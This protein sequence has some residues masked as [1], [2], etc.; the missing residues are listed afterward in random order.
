M[1]VVEYLQHR[2]KIA[3]KTGHFVSVE[4]FNVMTPPT[5]GFWSI[6]FY[7]TFRMSYLHLLEQL[8]ILII[9]FGTIWKNHIF[10]IAP[11]TIGAAVV[12]IFY[13]DN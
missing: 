7:K 4:H 5:E 10:I 2:L 3:C 13:G 6:F 8:K 12:N 9:I 11:P 1:H